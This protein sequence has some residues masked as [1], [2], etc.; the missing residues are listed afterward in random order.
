VKRIDALFDIER[1]SNGLSASE[2]L[3]VRQEQS[4]PLLA[5]LEAWLREERARP[6]ICDRPNEARVCNS[7]AFD[8]RPH[9]P[10]DGSTVAGC[11]DDLIL[12]TQRLGEFR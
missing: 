4:A 12:R 7:D 1:G 11:L 10:F 8:M 3:R 9:Q 2:R 6:G 5:E